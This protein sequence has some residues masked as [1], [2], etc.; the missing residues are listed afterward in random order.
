MATK[1]FVCKSSLRD[2]A[3][4]FLE[5]FQNNTISLLPM[6]FKGKTYQLTEIDWYVEDIKDG[7]ILTLK[8][9]GAER[10][11]LLVKE[12]VK[13]I[14]PA[15]QI[16]FQERF[17]EKEIRD[18]AVK[19]N[20][21]LKHNLKTTAMQTATET[22]CTLETFNDG[23][24]DAITAL[25][26]WLR[27]EDERM[28]IEGVKTY[29]EAI[30]LIDKII[31]KMVAGKP[32]GVTAFG[33]NPKTLDVKELQTFWATPS[34]KSDEPAL[35]KEKPT[36]QKTEEDIP[37]WANEAW[38]TALAIDERQRYHWLRPYKERWEM[39][40]MTDNELARELGKSVDT[41]RRWRR[42]L[43]KKNCPD[44]DWQRPT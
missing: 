43:E 34:P 16:Y 35:N 20:N 29:V 41:I 21:I 22:T 25:E 42:D 36:E 32:S 31:K 11:N 5:F 37:T 28:F 14:S 13:R 4:F 19:V 38:Y 2:W 26:K 44:M 9:N 23:F 1:R 10:K 6:K 24:A 12:K 15:I 27:L 8:M 7:K 18:F 40:E 39:G 30:P 33:V 17:L 3:K